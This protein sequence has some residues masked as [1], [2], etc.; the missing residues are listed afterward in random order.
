MNLYHYCLNYL[1]Y[2]KSSKN[3]ES[4][5]QNIVPNITNN[6]QVLPN[7]LYFISNKLKFI[8]FNYIDSYAYA[9]IN[10]IGIEN[11][12]LS[13]KLLQH[14]GNSLYFKKNQALL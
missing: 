9:A 6:P 7:N 11:F 10:A 4:N 1:L 12:I 14:I 8:F 2:Q 3:I 13:F 5:V